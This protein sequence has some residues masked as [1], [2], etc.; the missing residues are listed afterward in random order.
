VNTLGQARG[1]LYVDPALAPFP[2]NLLLPPSH[3]ALL[4]RDARYARSLFTFSLHNRPSSRTLEL[5]LS[6]AANS[7]V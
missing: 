7:L 1:S 5:K 2:L 3:S 4:A 6:S